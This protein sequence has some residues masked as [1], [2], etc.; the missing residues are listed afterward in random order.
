MSSIWERYTKLILSLQEWEKVITPHNLEKC[1]HDYE[2]FLR[3]LDLGKSLAHIY[4]VF[5]SGGTVI[6]VHTSSFPEKISWE[7]YEFPNY[8]PADFIS[9]TVSEA[10]THWQEREHMA[11]EWGRV[12]R[13]SFQVLIECG[14]PDIHITES[15]PLPISPGCWQVEWAETNFRL[16]NVLCAKDSSE[17]RHSA[18]HHWYSDYLYPQAKYLLTPELHLVKLR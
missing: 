7:A 17:A 8:Y 6:R 5:Y 1:V 12:V 11:G 10:R 14:Y 16:S 15:A 9:E 2:Q 18:E 13:A 4:H 3:S